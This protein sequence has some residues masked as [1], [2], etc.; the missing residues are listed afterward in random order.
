MVWPFSSKR[1]PLENLGPEDIV[2]VCVF[3]T[4]FWSFCAN[5][6]TRVIGPTGVGKSTVSINRGIKYIILT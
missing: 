3:V 5:P 2:I 6:D 4:N 1:E